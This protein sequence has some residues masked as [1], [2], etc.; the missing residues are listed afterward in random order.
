MVHHWKDC[1]VKQCLQCRRYKEL[2]E[3]ATS[4][5]VKANFVE[6]IEEIEKLHEEL[7]A[8]ISAIKRESIENQNDQPDL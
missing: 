6:L 7:S 4:S 2:Y 1:P 3:A 8:M 5:L